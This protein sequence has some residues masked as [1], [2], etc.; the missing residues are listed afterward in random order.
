VVDAA[1]NLLSSG[2]PSDY[3]SPEYC[4]SM[5]TCK[6]GLRPPNCCDE[7]I[8]A[9]VLDHWHYLVTAGDSMVN[10]SSC[11]YHVDPL[12]TNALDSAQAAGRIVFNAFRDAEWKSLQYP[13]FAEATLRSAEKLFGAGSAQVKSVTAAW[14]AVNVREDVSATPE[15]FPP[16][17]AKKVHPWIT[18]AWRP[19][20]GETSWDIQVDNADFRGPGVLFEKQG[21]TTVTTT[22]PARAYFSLALPENSPG[23]YVW[24]VR[25]HSD[26]AW[27]DC[28][29]INW[30]DGTGPLT[31]PTVS[32]G[33]LDSNGLLL[34]GLAYVY[35]PQVPGVPPSAISGYKVQFSQKNVACV[36][37]SGVPEVSEPTITPE[38]QEAGAHAVLFPGTQPNATYYA[39]VQPLGPPSISDSKPA[40]GPCVTV[41]NATAPPNSP[42]ISQPANGQRFNLYPPHQRDPSDPG[43]LQNLE[44]HWYVESWMT[45]STVQFRKRDDIGNCSG[46]VELERTVATP[47]SCAGSNFCEVV[48]TGDLFPTPYPGG[49]CWDVIGVG[50]N[51]TT[52]SPAARSSFR[53]FVEMGP[54]NRSPGVSSLSGT[55]G[56]RLGDTYGDPVTLTWEPVAGG[57]GR[58]CWEVTP[59]IEDPA[60]PGVEAAAQPKASSSGPICYTTGPALPRIFIDNRPPSTGYNGVDV[61]GRVE[62]DYIPDA[63]YQVNNGG[64]WD[65][66]PQSE[67]WCTT[68]NQ[69]FKDV[70]KCTRRFKVPA[71]KGK[72]VEI[73]VKAFNGAGAP[74]S[75]PAKDDLVHEVKEIVSFG[76]CGAK[77]QDCC[78][79][80]V[81]DPT[82]LT[83]NGSNKCVT[84]GAKVGDPCC[85]GSACGSGLDCNSGSCR[86][87]GAANQPCC[88]GNCNPGLKCD[89]T[90]KVPMPN[91][92]S[93]VAGNCGGTATFTITNLGNAP[94]GTFEASALCQT[95]GIPTD[96]GIGTQPELKAGERRDLLLDT[97]NCLSP[98]ILEVHVDPH[99]LVPDSDRNNNDSLLLCP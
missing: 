7:H 16:R 83:C 28:Y 1:G 35:F 20:P 85:A 14:Y 29:A 95:S 64:D 58:Y 47:A 97:R 19:Q 13:G 84:C 46:N 67:P 76:S 27:S 45:S 34:P 66:I 62:F 90:C 87:C 74:G 50:S 9:T 18:F 72:R 11:A 49:Y 33:T 91:L 88:K 48:L 99:Q 31:S 78:A 69:V 6:G 59:L 12:S 43:A 80:R 32:L 55:S 5:V 36:T 2:C 21:I 75:A 96:F 86:A 79:N 10:P 61:T 38:V 57:S 92:S 73:N 82:S 8:N 23:H 40:L 65:W 24:R 71:A 98:G 54:N 26:K 41:T 81:C 63:Q 51:G 3:K 17:G 52:Q 37:T 68:L 22:S 56:A 93:S 70:V 89:G 60:T 44:W 53:Y 77:D 94:T 39:H 30:F 4:A 25:P 15:I 42:T